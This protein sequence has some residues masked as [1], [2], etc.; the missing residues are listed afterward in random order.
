MIILEEHN[1][2]LET[3][4]GKLKQIL[5]VRT[6]FICCK[7]QKKN[8]QRKCNAKQVVSCDPWGT[9]LQFLIVKY[10]CLKLCHNN[11]SFYSSLPI[12]LVTSIKPFCLL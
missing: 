6:T 4:L 10:F 3:Q 12:N 8:A 9:M 7:T 5:E 1:R 2:Q 11:L